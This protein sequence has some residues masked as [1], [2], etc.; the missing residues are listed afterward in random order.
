MAQIAEISQ[1]AQFV[2]TA[3]QIVRTP[4]NYKDDKQHVKCKSDVWEYSRLGLSLRKDSSGM[5]KKAML[6][7]CILRIAP[8]RRTGLETTLLRCNL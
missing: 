5:S 7:D 3:F 2:F 8:K 1:I 6:G 4:L